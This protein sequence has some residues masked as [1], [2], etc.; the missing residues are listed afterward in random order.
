MARFSYKYPYICPYILL[1]KYIQVI[2]LY[3]FYYL[4]R[5]HRPLHFSSNSNLAGVHAGLSTRRLADGAD[6]KHGRGIKLFG[7]E[8]RDRARERRHQKRLFPVLKF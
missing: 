3:M 4:F 8:K 7:V 6:I 5:A 1:G 2:D